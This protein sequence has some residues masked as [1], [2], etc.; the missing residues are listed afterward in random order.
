MDRNINMFL[1]RRASEG[2]DV[3]YF[4]TFIPNVA[5]YASIIGLYLA[6]FP[7]DKDRPEWHWILLALVAILGVYTSWIEFI[8]AKRESRITFHKTEAVSRYMSEWVSR[9]GRTVIFSR[10]LSWGTEFNSKPALLKK[11]RS[12][13]LTIYLEKMTAFASE[14]QSEGAEILLYDGVCPKPM[15]RFTI[16]G[17]EKE[18]ARIAVAA[19]KGGLH[20]IYEFDFGEHPI[21]SIAQDLLNTISKAKADA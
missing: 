15:S 10:D 1:D 11:A 14:L 6:A 20:T 16:V 4:R 5:S 13:E 19:P 17:Y 9:P 18:G 3:R 8:T 12:K 21:F 2:V 7:W